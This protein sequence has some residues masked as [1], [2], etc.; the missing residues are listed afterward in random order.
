M[1]GLGV[2][3]HTIVLPS[4]RPSGGSADPAQGTLAEQPLHKVR[5]H[6][7]TYTAEAPLLGRHTGTYWWGHQV[8][9][10]RE[11]GEVVSDYR[12]TS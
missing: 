9:G 7:K 6:F 8:R 12:L 10:S 5:G 11:H 2:S 4:V 1:N 3:Y